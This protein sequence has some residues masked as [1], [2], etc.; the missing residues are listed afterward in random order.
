ML[1]GTAPDGA[2]LESVFLAGRVRIRSLFVPATFSE[3][4]VR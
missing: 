4:F 2:L 1:I 3:S